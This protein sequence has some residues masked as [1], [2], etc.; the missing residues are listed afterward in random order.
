MK[1]LV[2]LIILLWATNVFAQ[3][4]SQF[5]YVKTKGYKDKVGDRIEGVRIKVKGRNGAYRTDSRGEFSMDGLDKKYILERIERL[6]YELLDGEIIGT[7]IEVSTEPLRIVMV[8]RQQLAAEKE[9]I[10][11]ELLREYEKTKT[12]NIQLQTDIANLQKAFAEMADRLARVDYDQMDKKDREI[13]ECLEKGDFAKADSLILSKGAI[14]E[15]INNSIRGDK[16]I[17]NDCY[18]LATNAILRNDIDSALVL[19]DQRA[20]LAP[21]NIDCLLDVGMAYLNFQTN[22]EKAIEYYTQALFFSKKKYGK[23]HMLTIKCNFCLAS[24]F[25]MNRN[26]NETIPLIHDCIGSYNVPTIP[27]VYNRVDRDHLGETTT[28]AKDITFAED[29]SLVSQLYSMAMIIYGVQGNF[30]LAVECKNLAEKYANDDESIM[31]Q[32]VSTATVYI[33]AGVFRQTLDEVVLPYIKMVEEEPTD[34]ATVEFYAFAAMCYSNLNKAD[35]TIIYADKIIDYFD[36]IKQ[37][38]NQYYHLAVL[39]KSSALL[40]LEQLDSAYT[41][42]V[43]G[44]ENFQKYGLP[45]PDIMVQIERNK[46]WIQYSKGDMVGAENTVNEA[47][48]SII[49]I[50]EDNNYDYRKIK[51]I[52]ISDLAEIY[53]VSNRIDEAKDLTR[54]AFGELKDLYKDIG[55][56]HQDM[57]GILLQMAELEELTEDYLEA[58]RSYRMMYLINESSKYME[59]IEKCFQMASKSKKFRKTRD[60]NT[61][62]SE[63]EEFVK[64]TQ[65]GKDE[66]G[67]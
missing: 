18:I 67:N 34:I 63:Y 48:S 44:E 22:T 13:H 33:A 11:N 10:L 16:S 62:K 4:Y 9:A 43:Q 37:H 38:G 58:F 53:K 8:S 31:M 29:S 2:F 27:V 20:E 46:G 14:Q 30:N 47:L 52:L 32:L 28:S 17:L 6:G 36:V 50:S 61:L 45:Q 41:V 60:Y 66:A 15:R 54:L 59:A 65:G 51:A 21:T 56:D 19:L 25:F 64:K 3:S 26:F 35:S 40:A 57:I 5:G 24:A 7:N 42:I 23:N 49:D 55:Y 1:R 39:L 12:Q